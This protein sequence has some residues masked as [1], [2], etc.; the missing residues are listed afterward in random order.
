MLMNYSEDAARHATPIHVLNSTAY[1]AWFDAQDDMSQ[2]WLKIQGFDAN[3]GQVCCVPDAD[4]NIAFVCFGLATDD[5]FWLFGALSEKLPAGQ[6]VLDAK[7]PT[8]QQ[9]EAALAW[10]LH[11]YNFSRYKEKEMKEDVLLVLGQGV[12]EAGLNVSVEAMT[13]VRDLI[14]TPAEDMGPAQLAQAAEAV[15]IAHQAEFSQVV[16]DELLTENYPLVH[17]VGRASVREPRLLELRWGAE[18]STKVTLVG[19]GVCYDTG[20][21]SI[22]TN[23]GMFPMKKD[24]GGAAHALGLA[25]MIMMAGLPIQLRVLIPAVE[26]SIS[27]ASLRP[28]DVITSRKGLSVEIGN[29]DAEGRLILADALTEAQSD[30]PDLLLD[31]ATLTGAARIAMGPDVPAMFTPDDRLAREL[32]E[33]GEQ[34]ADPVWR[35]PLYEPYNKFLHSDVADMS[36]SAST[37]YGSAITAAL[38]LKRFVEPETTWVHLDLM[39]AN[40]RALPGRPKGGEAQ[41]LRTVFEYLRA[42]VSQ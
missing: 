2:N 1:P 22:K 6:Y 19:K 17:A 28:S 33:I 42:W 27:G 23:A 3:S 30:E 5:P 13:L 35:L 31:F 32:M 29:T 7:L 24:M 41:S 34:L 12:D 36:N 11:S 15:A 14:N 9:T 37:V 16:G 21:L 40:T 26:N 25:K 18:Y 4:G 20:G 8:A 38:F 10:A 39:A